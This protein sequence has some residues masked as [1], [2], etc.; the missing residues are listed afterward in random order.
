MALR[1]IQK[2]LPDLSSD[3]PANCSAGPVG[4]D[5]FNW[6]ATIMGLTDCPHQGGASSPIG[7]PLQAAEGAVHD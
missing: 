5:Q 2:E 3:S 7:L 1:R 4:N 6:L